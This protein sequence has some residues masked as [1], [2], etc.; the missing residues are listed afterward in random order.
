VSRL[1]NPSDR[2]EGRRIDVIDVDTGEARNIGTHLRRGFSWLP[3]QFGD[4]G[5]VFWYRD[6]PGA[7]RLFIDQGGALVRWDPE[8]GDLVHVVGGR[9]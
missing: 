4:A 6:Q 5:A 7:S 3:W 9:M 2:T 1:V 8:S